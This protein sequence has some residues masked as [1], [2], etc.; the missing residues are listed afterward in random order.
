MLVALR[1]RSMSRC[2]SLQRPEVAFDIFDIRIRMQQEAD[3]KGR[4]E[5]LSNPAV[6]PGTVERQTCLRHRPYGP[7]AQPNDLTWLANKAQLDLVRLEDFL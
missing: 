5:N 3:H 6:Q 4:V 2:A 1:L 7:S